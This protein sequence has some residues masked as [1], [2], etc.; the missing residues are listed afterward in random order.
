MSKE[1]QAA[2]LNKD[3]MKRLETIIAGREQAERNLSMMDFSFRCG[4]RVKEIASLEL[5]DVVGKN[6]KLKKSFTLESE[7]T[8]G[9]KSREIYLQ[10]KTLIKNLKRHLAARGYD[11][12]PLFLS[13]KGGSFSPNTMQMA[14]KRLF[15]AAGIEGASS[16]SGRRTFATTLINKGYNLVMVAE[17]LGHSSVEMT[18]KYV[19][20]NPVNNAKATIN[21]Y[22]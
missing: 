3:E 4:L 19:T 17:L 13:R 1:G 15:I 7:K 11:R 2:V 10:D 21:I 16:H 20:T 12:G 14:F 6:G 9:N 5:S 8:K 18:R 22:S